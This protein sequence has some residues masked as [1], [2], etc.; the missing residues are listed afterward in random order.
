M[1]NLK[2]ASGENLST[3][4]APKICL[5]KNPQ[6]YLSSFSLRFFFFFQ[7]SRFTEIIRH[8]ILA[9]TQEFQNSNLNIDVRIL[10]QVYCVVVIFSLSLI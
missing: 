6:K 8:Q 1:E 3:A 5:K 4:T 7:N 10:L 9:Q 2:Q